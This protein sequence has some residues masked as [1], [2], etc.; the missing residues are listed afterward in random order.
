MTFPGAAA[1]DCTSA[2]SPGQQTHRKY[3]SRLQGVGEAVQHS[4]IHLTEHL[5]GEQADRAIPA[6]LYS[7]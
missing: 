1:R 3:V 5:L 4:R 7:F 2:R 6:R